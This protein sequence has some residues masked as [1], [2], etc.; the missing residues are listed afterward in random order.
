MPGN[1]G[2]AHALQSWRRWYRDRKE[3][4]DA[5]AVSVAYVRVARISPSRVQ[6][7]TISPPESDPFLV[8]GDEVFSRCDGDD[9]GQARRVGMVINAVTYPS[10]DNAPVAGQ[11]IVKYGETGSRE[12]EALRSPGILLNHAAVTRPGIEAGI[13]LLSIDETRGEKAWLSLRDVLG[14]LRSIKPKSSPRLARLLVDNVI[15]NCLRI[16]KEHC[17]KGN[18]V[19]I[20]AIDEESVAI[21]TD[22]L[23]KEHGLIGRWRG[24]DPTTI[25]IPIIE[26][27]LQRV[28]DLV[29]HGDTMENRYPGHVCAASLFY[30][31]V[32]ELLEQARLLDPVA[33]KAAWLA[34]VPK[35]RSEA[36]NQVFLHD[37]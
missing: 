11:V 19:A 17:E 20:V 1:P 29:L 5:D 18:P 25:L 3:F 10:S 37:W 31:D 36:Y 33:L 28:N 21:L 27:A 14:V 32:I 13:R 22:R 23:W 24:A 7:S 4:V 6:F 9:P 2:L 16:A 12:V 35:R 15:D 26:M 30:K 8:A 34:L